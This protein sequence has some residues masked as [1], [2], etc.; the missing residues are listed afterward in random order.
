MPY[1]SVFFR[2][3]SNSA[4]L[5]Q[6]ERHYRVGDTADVTDAFPGI[7]AS[8][9]FLVLEL[10]GT[11]ADWAHLKAEVREPEPVGYD[12]AANGPWEGALIRLRRY[13]WDLTKLPA[14]TMQKLQDRKP[15]LDT[16]KT[17]YVRLSKIAHL[18]NLARRTN[19]AYLVTEIEKA[20]PNVDL[21]DVPNPRKLFVRA[22]DRLADGLDGIDGKVDVT[23]FGNVTPP[24]TLVDQGDGTFIGTSSYLI[25]RGDS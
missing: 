12:E 22:M 16:R 9:E 11:V 10:P 21:S 1:A 14:A 6:P 24:A 2:P 23:M 13:Y 3:R 25:D 19:R 15:L 5:N 20:F 18:S 17:W 4:P 7:M 8:E